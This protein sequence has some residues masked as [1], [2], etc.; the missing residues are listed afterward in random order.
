MFRKQGIPR[1]GL[2]Q[3]AFSN[4]AHT[5]HH[6]QTTYSCI[7]IKEVSFDEHKLH[8]QQN[9]LVTAKLSTVLIYYEL[10]FCSLPKWLWVAL[11]L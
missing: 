6:A 2:E 1:L 10:A 4:D 9:K 8:G 7:G 11:F 5:H 3:K